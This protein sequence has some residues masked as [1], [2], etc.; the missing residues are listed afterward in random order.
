MTKIC[1][2]CRTEKP[3]SEFHKNGDGTRPNCKTCGVSDALRHRDR[4][5]EMW[6]NGELKRPAKKQCPRCKTVKS[7]KHFAKVTT[8]KTGLYPYCFDCVR[9]N[10]R[11]QRRKNV[12]PYLLRTAR[13]R[14]KRL[15]VPFDLKVGDI[16]VPE[17][18][19]VLGIRLATGVSGFS[20]AS[21]SLD[22]VIPSLGYIKGN[23]RVISMR[24]NAI[25][26]DATAEELAKVLAYVRRELRRGCRK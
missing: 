3:I 21:P 11:N 17:K 2:K 25:K 24:A 1:T 15:G 12:A 18:C 16:H 8:N 14:A 6:A 13:S 20:D 10:A 7:A 23:I 26:R 19:P 4:I 5:R 22:R 9:E